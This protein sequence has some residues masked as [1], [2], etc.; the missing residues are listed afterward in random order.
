MPVTQTSQTPSQVNRSTIIRAPRSKV[1]KA[2]T[3][4]DQ[5]CKWF[6]VARVDPRAQFQPGVTARLISTHE[7][8]CKGFEFAMDV[9][10]IVPETLFAWQWHP[11]A[12]IAGEDLSAE[13]KTRVEFRLEDAEGGTRV[14]IT[15]SGFDALFAH[16]RASAYQDN[17]GGWKIQML[18]LEQYVS[19]AH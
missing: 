3:E 18:A 2:L 10:D 14:T 8:P 13:P 15:E 9:V 6:S 19:G 7:G 16:R 5:F 11:G 12:P 1:W 17:E 4:L